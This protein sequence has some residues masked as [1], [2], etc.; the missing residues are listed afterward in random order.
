MSDMRKHTSGSVTARTRD[1][2]RKPHGPHVA[3]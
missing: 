3:G 2:R 1:R